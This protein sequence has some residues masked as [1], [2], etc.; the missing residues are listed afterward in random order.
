MTRGTIH[1][2]QERC[3]GCE[4][5]TTVCP[6]Q[7]IAIDTSRLNSKGFHPARLIEDGCTGCA[8]CAIICP[9]VCI[10]VYREA[11]RAVPAV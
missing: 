9:D 8:V 6:Q 11:R 3:K 5:C 4:L 7:I 10:T 1:I 2:D